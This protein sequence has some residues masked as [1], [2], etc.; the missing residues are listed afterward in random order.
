MDR[1]SMVLL[2]AALLVHGGNTDA[3]MVYAPAALGGRT[4]FR[5]NGRASGCRSMVTRGR[6][7][8]AATGTGNRPSE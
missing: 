3:N 1:S 5:A 4:G 7:L 8:P 6:L 2:D